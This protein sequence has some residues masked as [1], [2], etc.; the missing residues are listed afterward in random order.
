[1]SS[2]TVFSEMTMLIFLQ[3]EKIDAVSACSKDDD[4]AIAVMILEKLHR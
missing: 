4:R 3:E 1:V 2:P